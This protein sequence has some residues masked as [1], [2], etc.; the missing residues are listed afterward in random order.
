MVLE[1][2]DVAVSVA[3]GVDADAASSKNIE[4]A[5]GQAKRAYR[6]A[7]DFYSKQGEHE[8]AIATIETALMLDPDYWYTNWVK[9]KIL[10]AA[11]D[12]KAAVKQGKKAMDMGAPDSYRARYEKEMKGW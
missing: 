6:N 12:T 7:A 1:W 2:A 8:K 4:T 11:G 5:V 10:Y 3:I 9:A